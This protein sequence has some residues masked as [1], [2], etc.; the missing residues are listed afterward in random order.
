MLFTIM[1]NMHTFINENT[2]T[3]LGNILLKECFKTTI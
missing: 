3:F 1:K 2:G